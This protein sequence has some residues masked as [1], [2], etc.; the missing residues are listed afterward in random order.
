MPEV[1]DLMVFD[2]ILCNTD[3]RVTKNNYAIRS[4]IKNCRPQDPQPKPGHPMFV[5]I[6]QGSSFYK[7]TGPEGNPLTGIPD[8]PNRFCRGFRKTTAKRVIDMSSKKSRH[9]TL[10]DNLKK[11]VPDHIIKHVGR[12]HVKAAQDRLDL[13]AQHLTET[14]PKHFSEEEI[15]MFDN[16]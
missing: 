13:L 11:R 9:H 14:C 6:D 5:H 8:R 7:K 3:R 15:H 12:D 1:S 2:Y 10:W 4:C 16:A